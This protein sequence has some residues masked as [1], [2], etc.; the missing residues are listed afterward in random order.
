VRL[1]LERLNP[2]IAVAVALVLFL[3]LEGFLLYRYQ[4]A[5]QSPAKKLHKK[6]A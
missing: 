4:Q 6:T 3:V 1:L 5:L 2:P